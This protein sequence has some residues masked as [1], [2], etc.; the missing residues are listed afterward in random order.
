MAKLFSRPRRRMDLGDLGLP[1]ESDPGVFARAFISVGRR[2]D[3]PSVASEDESPIADIEDLGF[4]AESDPTDF[5]RAFAAL[6]G[7]SALAR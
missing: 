7:Q 6:R 5:A 1:T 2:Y 3:L 4:P